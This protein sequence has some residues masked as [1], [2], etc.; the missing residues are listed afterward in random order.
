MKE[1]IKIEFNELAKSVTADVK[2][3]VEQDIGLTGEDRDYILAETERLFLKA[4][5][6]SHV[7]TIKKNL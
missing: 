3:E 1:T 2:I 6:F 5:E 7:Q 4:R